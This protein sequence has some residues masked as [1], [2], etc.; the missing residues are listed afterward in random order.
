[1]RTA[2]GMRGAL[3]RERSIRQPRVEG[4]QLLGVMGLKGSPEADDGA[5]TLGL[6]GIMI[7]LETKAKI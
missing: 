5:Y 4:Y 3:R 6:I 7:T 1:M 2:R